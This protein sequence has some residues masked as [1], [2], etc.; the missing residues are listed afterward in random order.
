MEEALTLAEESLS[1][2]TECENCALIRPERAQSKLPQN[3]P[4]VRTRPCCRHRN[5]FDFATRLVCGVSTVHPVSRVF[6]SASA[7]GPEEACGRNRRAGGNS[8]CSAVLVTHK[9]RAGRRYSLH[10]S[11]GPSQD[12]PSLVS[13]GNC[14]YL[15][16]G[17][18]LRS[19]S[20]LFLISPSR[21]R[22]IGSGQPDRGALLIGSVCRLLGNAATSTF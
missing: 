6:R 7:E 13:D 12:H 14:D 9:L 1:T 10:N 17:F 3:Q 4:F 5:S 18:C 19:N 16:P 11:G 22:E 2:T 21:I 15:V 8:F 20:S